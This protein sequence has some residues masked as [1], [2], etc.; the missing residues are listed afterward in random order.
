MSCYHPLKGFVLGVNP[1]GKKELSIQSY[2]TD[3]VEVTQEGHVLP[4]LDSVR[5][6]RCF[7]YI[8]EYVDIPCGQCIGC[9]LDYSREWANRCML[10]LSDHDEAWFVTLTYDDNHLPVSYYADPN[11]GLAYPSHTLDKRDVQLFFKRL[12]KVTGQKLRYYMCG[13]Y[14]PKNLRPHYHLII[15][16]LHLD[17]LKPWSRSPQGYQYYRSETIEKAW[18]FPCRDEYGRYIDDN[19]SVA[20][21]CLVGAVTWESCAYTAR[22]MTKKLKGD[23]ADFYTYFNL[24]PPF[25]LMSR[26]PG[27][28]R[29]YYDTHDPLDI[30]TRPYLNIS[31]ETGGRKIMAPA[32]YHRLFDIDYPQESQ[33]VKEARR[34]LSELARQAKLAQTDLSYLELLSVQERQKTKA[35]D[36]LKR[37]L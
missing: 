7:R 21:Y 37:T 29:G 19:R 25:S 22:Y 13:E 2:N 34:H 6:P 14:G 31:T 3:H 4:A 12:R 8:K 5:S 9:R 15:F 24:I 23:F 18:S 30:C 33:R 10:E 1:S 28:A 26:K 36:A 35:A 16:G 11:T 27:I 32:Y 20:G 17:D